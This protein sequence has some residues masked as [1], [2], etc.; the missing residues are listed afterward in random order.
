MKNFLSFKEE[1][2]L[3][4]VATS[5]RKTL[6]Q[7]VIE[8]TGVFKQRLLKSAVIYGANASGKSNLI[9]AM[10]H[11][12]YFLE[13]STKGNN[14][15]PIDVNP[16]AFDG[17]CAD[18]PS[19]FELDFLH[20][21]I[22]Y[23]YGFSVDRK[24]VHEERMYHFPK[25][26]QA[27][28][29]ERSEQ[30]FNFNRA[31]LKELKDL[32][33]KTR[34]NSLFL[35]VAAQFNVDFANKVNDWLKGFLPLPSINFP[36]MEHTASLLKKEDF[37][38]IVLD[39]M[40]NAD[41]SVLDIVVDEK[42]RKLS[43]YDKKILD[44]ITQKIADEE[45]LGESARPEIKMTK[46]LD[47]KFYHRVANAGG[48]QGI[49]LDIELESDGTQRIFQLSG[50]LI[51]TIR[52]G[53]KVISDELDLRLHPL[54]S[55]WLIS[56]FHNYKKDSSAQLIFTTHNAELL[57]PELFR[58]DQIWFAEKDAST[59]ASKIFSL[60]DYKPRKDE[61]FRKNYLA[62]RYGAVPILRRFDE[63]AEE[64]SPQT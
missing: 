2:T 64:G 7:N 30:E 61:N 16:F 63:Y 22:R 46:D 49:P 27:M 25:G 60:S 44:L 40:S 50:Y 10:F 3:S 12:R 53:L 20:E 17:E 45:P 54:L 48:Q 55:E 52:N 31:R 4:M 34:H 51:D 29:F 58:R 11:V 18:K 5:D 43:E 33:P 28:L 23:I 41:F 8:P 57:S 9:E 47:I 35:T 14:Q 15:T 21:G 36:M 6:P 38:K 37:K 19:M 1:T 42:E 59:G 26:Q 62:G 56:F 39:F 13:N 32:T 24:T